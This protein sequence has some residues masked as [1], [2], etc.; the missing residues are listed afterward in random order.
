MAALPYLSASAGLGMLGDSGVGSVVSRSYD[1][2]TLLIGAFGIDNGPVRLEA[3]AGY[4]KNGVT[5]SPASITMKS[6][7]ANGYLDLGLPFSPLKPFVLAGGGVATV[8]EHN[9]GLL[10]GDTVLAWQIGAGAAYSLA[11]AVTLD[12]QYRY[13]DASTPQLAGYRYS[14]GSHNILLGLRFGL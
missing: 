5:N 6:Y 2:G 12:V 7:M 14:M 13:F 11:P 4:R 10:S 8:D 3:E 9:S 1:T